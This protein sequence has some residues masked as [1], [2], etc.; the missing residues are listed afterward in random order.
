MFGALENQSVQNSGAQCLKLN[1]CLMYIHV[2][3]GFNVIKHT[4]WVNLFLELQLLQWKSSSFILHYCVEREE[5]EPSKIIPFDMIDRNVTASAFTSFAIK[6]ICCFYITQN[7]HLLGF[8]ET[9][10]HKN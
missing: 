1:R 5:K 10:C 3:N 8:T 9:K 6:S 7:I 2:M 4:C